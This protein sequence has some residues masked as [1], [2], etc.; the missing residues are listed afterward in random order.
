MRL[1]GR[2]KGRDIWDYTQE[3]RARNKPPENIKINEVD[4]ICDEIERRTGDQWVNT[5]PGLQSVTA[6]YLTFLQREVFAKLSKEDREEYLDLLL[7]RQTDTDPD[8][9]RAELMPTYDYAIRKL[10]EDRVRN[11]HPAAA[12][13]A[14]NVVIDSIKQRK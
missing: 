4:P 1:F 5:L 12:D 2:N 3:L 7:S 11:L 6:S 10:G 8:T 13:R 14:V 9:W